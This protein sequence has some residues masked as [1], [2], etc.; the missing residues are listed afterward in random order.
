[1]LLLFERSSTFQIMEGL[2][3]L[4]VLILFNSAA[5]VPIF[6]RR[7]WVWQEQSCHVSVQYTPGISELKPSSHIRRD[8][9]GP[10]VAA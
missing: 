9:S 8:T 5:C 3:G 4:R 7:H 1:M 2:V 10:G 6:Q